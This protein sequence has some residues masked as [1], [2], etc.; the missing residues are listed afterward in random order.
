MRARIATMAIGILLITHNR[1][2]EVM[3]DITCNILG[4]C[5]LNST[6]ITVEPD[7]DT[8]ILMAQARKARNM[9]DVG[10]GVLVLTDLYGSTPANIACS[11]NQLPDTCVV[12]G[13]SIPILTKVMN[14]PDLTLEQITQKALTAG[15][16]GCI[17]CETR[18]L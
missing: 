2:G 18:E 7:S 10:D 3:L 4:N 12:T 15:K 9:L 17:L 13:L 6:S 8:N 16:E 11:L 5:P 1:L 14:Y